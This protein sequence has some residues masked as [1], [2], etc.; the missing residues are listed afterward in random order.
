[1]DQSNILSAPTE[2]IPDYAYGWRPYANEKMIYKQIQAPHGPVYF[3]IDPGTQRWIIGDEPIPSFLKLSDGRRRLSEIIRIL[4]TDPDLAASPNG[5]VSIAQ[6][7]QEAGI[8]FNNKP[9][10]QESS[11]PV[12]NK[13]EPVGLH[14]EITNACNMTCTHC[15][16]SSGRKLP[17]EM[18]LEEI[19][20]TI[21]ML[22]PFSGK[23]IAISGGEPAVRKE[24]ADIVEYCVVE[25]GHDV[26]LYSN[27]KKFPKRLAERILD[28][29]QRS[30]T[31]VRLQI[32]LEGATPKTSDSVRGEG[33][34][35]ETMKTLD[36]FKTI[37]LN[38]SIILFVC[39]TKFN[40]HEV[41]E[42]IKIAK[43]YDVS[44]LGFSQ[45]Q[46]QGNAINTPWA[47]IAPTTEEWVA[48]GD[49]LLSYDN[50]RLKVFGNFYGDLHNCTQ[51]TGFDLDNPLFPKHV[52]FYNA[53]PRVTP[54]GAIYADQ[55]W[56]DP[57]WILG[58]IQQDTLDECFDSPKFYEQLE[59]MRKRTQ[60]ILDC[61][62]CEWRSLCEGGS[63]GHTYA[64][65]G[66]MDEKDLFCEG[67]IH[68]FN[69]YV[70]HQIEKAFGSQQTQSNA[71]ANNESVSH[72]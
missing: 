36:M 48:I 72:K 6:E 15:Y 14:L 45:W 35:D 3:I 8:L 64:E 38:R 19:Y 10:H 55:L 37:G 22:P 44:M 21:D 69:K 58:H 20:K 50:P 53:F 1:M 40:L 56:V 18:T 31:Q 49:K 33:S 57:N 39:L 17:N 43:Y 51:Q 11:L 66:H 4:S 34:F 60:N 63:A 54:E 46:K 13:C 9:E 61:Q 29:N 71:P 2:F 12:Y 30:T 26:D 62:A 47:S 16:V 27:G 24:C 5:F 32:S 25:C 7:L 59:Q 52:Y 65:Y 41:D 23:R 70:N 67:R 68:W 28:I 42:L